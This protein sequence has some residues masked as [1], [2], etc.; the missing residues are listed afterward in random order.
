M[1]R[2]QDAQGLPM[3]I[4]PIVNIP[5]AGRLGVVTGTTAVGGDVGG[6]QYVSV[7]Y[8]ERVSEDVA[9]A[10][11]VPAAARAEDVV[12]NAARVTASA[13]CTDCGSDNEK[14]Q[15]L[16]ELRQQAALE[17]LRQRDAQIRQEENAHA[18]VAGEAGGP[19][20]YTYQTG[21][22]GRLYAV[23]GKVPIHLDNPSGDPAALE[24]D[25]A[26]LA[27]AANAA[28]SPSAADLSIARLGYRAAADAVAAQ[29]PRVD[30]VG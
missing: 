20:R 30:I 12:R 9:G 7:H 11:G 15:D 21:P 28:M 8:R 23:S 29:K 4:G 25:A 17:E 10:Q 6:R 3:Q 14:R 26:Q 19:P 22:D 18:A 27:A 13:D 2:L 24:A 1:C 16:L 5:G